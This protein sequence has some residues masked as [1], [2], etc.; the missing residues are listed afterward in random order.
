MYKN[1]CWD[2]T[3]SLIVP[4]IITN[5][6][7]TVST[8]I[9]VSWMTYCLKQKSNK[10]SKKN[11]VDDDDI[12]INQ[13]R[14]LTKNPSLETTTNTLRHITENISSKLYADN[15]MP[16]EK[17]KEIESILNEIPILINYFINQ[18][19]H[20]TTVNNLNQVTDSEHLMNVLESLKKNEK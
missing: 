10:N 4:V 14:K 1:E 2:M 16:V 3:M 8:I 19:T 6:V 5:I 20:D 11:N 15:K 9:I 7:A 13:V 18:S 12:I 17:K